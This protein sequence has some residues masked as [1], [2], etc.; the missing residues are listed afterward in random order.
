MMKLFC[1]NSY[2]L[3]IDQGTTNRAYNVQTN[4]NKFVVYAKFPEA[5]QSFV[6]QYD[7]PLIFYVNSDPAFFIG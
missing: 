7:I 3:K 6:L 2:Y 5:V 1:E 4:A